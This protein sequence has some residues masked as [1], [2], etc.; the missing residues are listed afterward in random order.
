LK[1]DPEFHAERIAAQK[2]FLKKN[3]P[4]DGLT[5]AERITRIIER[6]AQETP[7]SS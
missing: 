1:S 6:L 5:S 4:D 3:L 7:P 2:R